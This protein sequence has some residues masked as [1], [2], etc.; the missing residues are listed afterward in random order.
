LAPNT[1]RNQGIRNAPF[2]DFA[3]IVWN[4]GNRQGATGSSIGK[5]IV[6]QLAHVID[7]A[8]CY[9]GYLFPLWDAK[10]QT[11]ASP[12]NH[13]KALTPVSASPMTNWCTSDVPS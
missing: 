3:Y 6:R 11:I 10:R 5:S 9:V 1:V 2:P 7:G 8:I 4:N 13:L 12:M